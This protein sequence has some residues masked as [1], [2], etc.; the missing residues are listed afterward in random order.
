MIVHMTYFSSTVVK[1]KRISRKPINK[2]TNVHSIEIPSMLSI[3][4]GKFFVSSVD[5]NS[6]WIK[7]CIKF[8][9]KIFDAIR[10]GVE[11]L[12][13]FGDAC[14]FGVLLLFVVVLFILVEWVVWLYGCVGILCANVYMCN[15][16]GIMVETATKLFIS[17]LILAAFRQSSS[18]S[19]L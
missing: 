16:I 11:S 13:C 10:M 17:S 7:H 6:K 8:W 5:L 1:H 18:S 15:A 14:N 3:F 2:P 4:R 19:S 9:N 12:V